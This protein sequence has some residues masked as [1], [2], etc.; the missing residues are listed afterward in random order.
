M[1]R[2]KVYQLEQTQIKMKQECVLPFTLS[3]GSAR[4]ILTSRVRLTAT[5]PRS[6]CCDTSLSRAVCSQSLTLH[7]RRMR[8]LRV[9]R[10]KWATAP[11]T[12]SVVLWPT[13][14][15][16]VPVL[17]LP[18]PRISRPPSIPFNSLPRLLRSPR[19]ALLEDIRLVSVCASDRGGA[20]T[21]ADISFS[22]KQVMA[23]HLLLPHPPAPV[24]L[25]ACLRDRPLPNRPNWPTRI[26]VPPLRFP[27]RRLPT[28]P[29]F[30]IAWVTCWQI[31][32]QRTCPRRKSV[33]DKIGM[34]C[35]TRKC[36]GFWM[37]TWCIT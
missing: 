1:I 6:E 8:A 12:F 22:V 29:L 34:P 16:V 26:P 20:S 35:S 11:A 24:K 31:G 15:V 37:S 14:E 7:L 25:V 28:S 9:N 32:T 5:K 17:S 2:Q 19:R 18:P 3:R 21:S 13:Q 27:V 23:R 30:A 36:S 10:R 4:S 33:K